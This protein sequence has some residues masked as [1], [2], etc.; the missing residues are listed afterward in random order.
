MCG[1]EVNFMHIDA[2][3]HFPIIVNLKI[4]LQRTNIDGNYLG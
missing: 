1:V 2:R 3:N 4:L